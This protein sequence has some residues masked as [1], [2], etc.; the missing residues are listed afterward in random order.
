MKAEKCDLFSISFNNGEQGLFE[1]MSSAERACITR[2][3]STRSIFLVGLCMEE[4]V[5]NALKYGSKGKDEINFNI[6]ISF[7]RANISMT[8]TDNANPFNPLTDAPIPDLEANIEDRPTGGLGIHLL[9]SMTTSINYQ[10]RNNCNNIFIK[11]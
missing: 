4:L 1:A 7:A 10:Y 9:K 3:M 5:T 8:I 11:I 6:E 2:G